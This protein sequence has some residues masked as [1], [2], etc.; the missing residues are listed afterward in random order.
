M[1]QSTTINIRVDSDVKRDLE[2]LLDK[3]GMNIS[4][5]V[6]MLFRQMLMEEALPFLPKVH[7]N[8]TSLN[9]YLEA[10][11][12]KDIESILQE[13]EISNKNSVEIDWGNPVGEE[14]W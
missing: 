9:E 1:A 4:V 7:N 8:R 10:Y 5:V 2:I 11:H 6:N 12:G 3:L 13:A 14:L